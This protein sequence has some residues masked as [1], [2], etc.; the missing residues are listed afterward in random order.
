MMLR[1]KIKSQIIIYFAIILSIII[2]LQITLY[3]FLRVKSNE[4]ISSVFQSIVQNTVSQIEKL[5]NDMEKLSS[6]LSVNSFIQSAL[7]EYTPTELVRNMS[8]I[9]RVLDDYR[10]RNE[11]IAMLALVKNRTLLMSSESDSLY[12]DA[13]KIIEGIEPTESTDSIITPSFLHNQH[14]YFGCITPIFP[15]SAAYYTPEHPGHYILCLYEMKTINYAPYGFVD[16]SQ[17]SMTLTDANDRILLSADPTELG[18][19]FNIETDA[20]KSLHQT[21]PL[22]NSDWKIT[23][24]MPADS[25]FVLR[26]VSALFVIFMVVFNLVM[27]TIM[28]KIINDIIIKRIILL[29]ENV[30]KIS[31]SSTTYR[32]H[33]KYNDELSDIVVVINQVLDKI[34]MLNQEKLNTLERL[35]QTQLLQKETQILYLCG[36]ISPHFLYNS[37]S[38]IQGAAF[39]YNAEEIINMTASL[40]KVFRY[41]SSSLNLSTIRQDLDCAIEYFNVINMRRQNMITLINTVDDELLNVRCLKMIYQPIL[42]NVLK[43]AFSVEDTGTVTISSVSD[44]QKAI[45]EI[46]DNGKGMT[47]E[48][49]RTLRNNLAKDSLVKTDSAA[50]IGLLNVNMRLKLFYNKTCG[51]T[52]ES[53]PGKETVIRVIFEKEIPENKLPQQNDFVLNCD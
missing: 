15:I 46:R 20:K 8:N 17:I 49:I 28:L 53:T 32:V 6:L 5:N 41:F 43:H 4:I 27:L 50:H 35:Y 12:E 7:Y 39:K 22:K 38:Y 45:I 42:E 24:F 23:V 14:T 36:Q 3:S 48:T 9:Q 11:N 29:K 26:D 1:L 34:H 37:M 21:L 44:P 47:E 51:I 25:I 18:T 52:F 2:A 10:D 33:Y 40:A 16:S 30:A 31:N 19:V 13:R